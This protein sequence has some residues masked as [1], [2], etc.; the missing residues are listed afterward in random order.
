MPGLTILFA[1][2]YFVHSWGPKYMQH[3]KPFALE[4][5]LVVYNFI[6]V[7]AS[8]YLFYEVIH[9]KLYSIIYYNRK[10]IGNWLCTLGTWCC[11]VNKI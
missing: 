7:L 8:V 10:Q 11:L 1:Y 6:Q 2:H 4:N 3:R 5:L 9:Y